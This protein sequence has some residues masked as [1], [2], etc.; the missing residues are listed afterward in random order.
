VR[1]AQD[2]PADSERCVRNAESYVATI[3]DGVVLTEEG[4]A[5]GALPGRV[6]R[7]G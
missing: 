6:P 7:G 5:S 4:Q 2:V 1:L 3:V